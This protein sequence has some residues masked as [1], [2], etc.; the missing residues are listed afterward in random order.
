MKHA[1]TINIVIC[2]LI[3]LTVFVMREPLALL[4]LLMLQQMPYGLLQQPE[5]DD[6]DYEEEEQPVGFTQKLKP[7]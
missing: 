7:R 6:E 1:L 2:L 3:A 5:E 4:C